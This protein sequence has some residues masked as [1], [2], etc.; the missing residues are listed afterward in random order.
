MRYAVSGTGIPY[1][2]CF[3]YAIS[4]TDAGYAA[5]RQRKS[6]SRGVK[7]SARVR[8]TLRDSALCPVLIY[9]SVEWP[10]VYWALYQDRY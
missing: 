4:G 5:T 9:R 6:H 2:L 8:M 10:I 1:V 3:F 7:N